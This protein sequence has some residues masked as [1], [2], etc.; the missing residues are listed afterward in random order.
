MKA[1]RIVVAIFMVAAVFSLS[2]CEGFMDL[3]ASLLGGSSGLNSEERAQA[4][5]D[6]LNTDPVYRGETELADHFSGSALTKEQLASDIVSETS[7][8]R[9][10][11]HDFTIELVSEVNNVITFSFE[12][13]N[14]APGTI[15]FTMELETVDGDNFLIKTLTLTLDA[16]SENPFILRLR[17][18]E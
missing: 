12:N 14:F 11:N 18:S 9:Y 8:L 15:V 16:D 2:S 4:F 1:L 3:L 6:T 17:V 7:P 13:G 5:I 10:A